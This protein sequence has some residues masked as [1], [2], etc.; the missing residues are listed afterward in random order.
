MAKARKA[1]KKSVPRPQAKV[2]RLTEALR[3]FIES[4]PAAQSTH[5]SMGRSAAPVA[6]LHKLKGKIFAI[7]SLRQE[8]VIVKCDPMLIQALKQQYKGIGHKSHLDKRYWI[9]VSLDA[10]VPMKEV[11]RLVDHSYGLVLASL[12]LKQQAELERERSA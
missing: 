1:A 3:K 10:D 9:A 2:S 7:Q 11:R 6:V 5:L 12:T 4:L 8:Y